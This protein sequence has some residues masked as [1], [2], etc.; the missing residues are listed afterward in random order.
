[1]KT[2][3]RVYRDRFKRILRLRLGRDRQYTIGLF[4]IRLP[5]EHLLP[6]H[7]SENRL[8][9]RFLPFVADL[10]PAGSTIIDVGAN[11]G[12]TLASMVSKNSSCSYVC[13]EPEDEFFSYLSNTKSQILLRYPQM[14]IDLYQQILSSMGA[15]R[16]LV[17][18]NGTRTTQVDEFG[19]N[20]S[21]SL[22]SVIDSNY[23]SI[24]LLKVD[25]DGW[26]WDVIL[27]SLKVIETHRPIIYFEMYV[28]TNEALVGYEKALLMLEKQNYEEF[29]VFDSFGAF[30]FYT[31]DISQILEFSKYLY[32]QAQ[33]KSTQTMFYLDILC[34]VKDQKNTLTAALENFTS[35]AVN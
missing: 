32:V 18:G 27:S 22:D 5:A 14:Q 29:Y 26:D 25:V 16:G 35:W 12:D 20:Q 11:T 1:M 7:Q 31:R 13:I 15:K 10:L 34:G 28:Q 9:D 24:S 8:Y 17:G 2:R 19:G 6:E 30:I 4:D 3:F 33:G 23:D 21:V